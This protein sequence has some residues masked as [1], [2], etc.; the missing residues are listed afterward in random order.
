ML[1]IGSTKPNHSCHPKGDMFF[2]HGCTS[3]G[4]AADEAFGQEHRARTSLVRW[5]HQAC[6]HESPGPKGSCK[7]PARNSNPPPEL[8]ANPGNSVVGVWGRSGGS[9]ILAIGSKINN[10]STLPRLASQMNAQT[11]PAYQLACQF[12]CHLGVL[13]KALFFLSSPHCIL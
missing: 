11:S 10:I 5:L 6:T 4:E 1:T 8:N 13:L 7:P 9:P 12:V 3:T 2:K